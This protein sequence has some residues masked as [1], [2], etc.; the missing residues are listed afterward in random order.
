MEARVN[1]EIFQRERPAGTPTIEE[2]ITA[3]TTA[4]RNLAFAL[5]DESVVLRVEKAAPAVAAAET[6]A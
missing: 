5:T 4:K 6:E 3:Y 1:L 2:L